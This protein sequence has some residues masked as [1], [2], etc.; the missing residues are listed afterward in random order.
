MYKRRE[1]KR[2]DK[3]HTVKRDSR[4]AWRETGRSM[5]IEFFRANSSTTFYNW[6]LNIHSETFLPFLFSN[7][8]HNSC[9]KKHHW[10]RQRII[11][12]CRSIV[13][14][15]AIDIIHGSRSDLSLQSLSSEQSS[16]LFHVDQRGGCTIEH[17]GSDDRA[18]ESAVYR[19]FDPNVITLEEK[20]IVSSIQ[21]VSVSSEKER[22]RTTVEYS[23]LVRD[24]NK[25]RR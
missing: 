2:E 14:C 6:R 15:D 1:H 10:L 4:L 24:W 18:V 17:I 3:V 8:R 13:C 12:P 7:E 19:L 21:L 25:C 22:N 23:V 5:S 16:R 9:W 11:R 20:R